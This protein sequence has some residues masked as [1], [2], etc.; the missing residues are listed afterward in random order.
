MKTLEIFGNP[1]AQ[2]I[3]IEADNLNA[4]QY[5]REDYL[6][7]IDVITIDPP[8]NTDINYIGYKDSNY[9]E[10]W[11][12]FMA[13]RLILARNL[14]SPN[15]VMF[16]NIDENEL[17]CL[18]NI[19]YSLFG[20]KNVNVLIWPKVD[21]KFD[22]NRIEKPV[23]NIRSTHEFIVLCYMNKENTHFNDTI[24]DKPMESIVAGFGTTSSA[25]D[26]ICELLGDRKCFSTPKPV[27]LIREII[28]VASNKD[29]I[30]LDFFAG[31][32]TAGHATMALNKDDGGNRRFILIT[33]NESNICRNVTVPRLKSA[34]E[35]ENLD[36]G[37]IF[38]TM[39]E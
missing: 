24:E 33:N 39:F 27:A 22:Q 32:G 9:S 30:I 3:V 18:M 20:V 12:K 31:S 34:I 23:F 6:G 14:L 38:K 8:Y 15:G 13:D 10:G 28:R 16:I 7:K 21:P 5:L 19:C 1:Q 37:F 2:N 25:K 17:I 29:S 26:E 35:H 36:S 4:L 11:G